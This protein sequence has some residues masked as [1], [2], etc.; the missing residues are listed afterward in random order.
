MADKQ[1]AAA[2]E[3]RDED[4]AAEGAARA[5]PD[6]AADQPAL[7]TA[8][9]QKIARLRGKLR[10]QFGMAVM[11]LMTVPRYRNQSLSDL[12]HVLLDPMLN[13]RVAM[14]YPGKTENAAASDLT[15]FAIWASVSEAVD[16]KIREQ[17]KSGVFPVR[18]KSDEWNSGSINWLLDVIADDPKTVVSVIANFRSVTGKGELR[19]HPIITRLVDPGVLETMG[20]RRSAHDNDQDHG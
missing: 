17:I 11:A 13:D 14:A 1:S 20:G 15:G 7:D 12:R 8:A 18:L 9:A 2:P 10:E 6:Q 19:L 3:R 4:R 16:E 5:A